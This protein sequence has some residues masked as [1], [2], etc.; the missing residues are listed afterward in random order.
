MANP[1]RGQEFGCVLPFAAN[2]DFSRALA[3][4]AFAAAATHGTRGFVSERAEDLLSRDLSFAAANWTNPVARG[5]TIMASQ[6]GHT[7]PP[8]S[9]CDSDPGSRD[10]QPEAGG[11]ASVHFGTPHDWVLHA[12]VTIANV[13]QANGVIQAIDTVLLPN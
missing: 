5:V 12:R 8:V 2:L 13:F 7:A 11:G 9:F 4:L 10:C 6:G 3:S 1:R